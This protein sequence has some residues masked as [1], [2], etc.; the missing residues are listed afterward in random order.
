MPP[1]DSSRAENSATNGILDVEEHEEPASAKETVK[2]V[3]INPVSDIPMKLLE[4]RSTQC[5][6]L[7]P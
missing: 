4:E 7:R 5:I 6:R 1:R 2:A 3:E